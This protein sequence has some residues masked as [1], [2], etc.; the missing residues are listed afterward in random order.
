[1]ATR[2][3]L[4]SLFFLL[5]ATAFCLALLRIR[6][7]YTGSHFFHFLQWNLFLAWVPLG[8][9]SMA[10]IFSGSR[11]LPGRLLFVAT[12]ALWILFL[13]NAPYLLTD[14]IHLRQWDRMP[15][16]FDSIMIGAYGTTGLLLGL[17]S[18]LTVHGIV[19]RQA[20]PVV[21]WL[22]AAGSL[23]LAAFGTYLGRFGRFNSWDTLYRPGSIAGETWDRFRHPMTH[24]HAIEYTAL[25]ACFLLAAYVVLFAL[26]RKR[27]GLV[28]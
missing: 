25:F 8:V 3:R 23:G 17:V 10:A 20:G 13:P 24:A 16:W 14:F 9:A 15:L 22:F 21:G 11:S 12:L 7:S 2:P 18:L 6:E 26:G 1:M 19:G 4:I 28:F 27:I 5:L